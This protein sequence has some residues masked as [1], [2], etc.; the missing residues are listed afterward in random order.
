MYVI[1]ERVDA[2]VSDSFVLQTFHRTLT[3]IFI[4][5]AIISTGS[6]I[7]GTFYISGPLCNTI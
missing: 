4:L 3:G 6:L 1:I 2:I 7:P 5:A